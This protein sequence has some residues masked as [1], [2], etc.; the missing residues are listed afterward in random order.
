M[1]FPTDEDWLQLLALNLSPFTPAASQPSA[2]AAETADTALSGR[3]KN[4]AVLP[5]TPG[6]AAGSSSLTPAG[7]PPSA[8]AARAH[9]DSI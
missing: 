6:A 2:K 8:E 3:S 5:D 9:V 7:A 1:V 4:V